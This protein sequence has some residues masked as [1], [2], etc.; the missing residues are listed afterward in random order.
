[1]LDGWDVW[2]ITTLRLDKFSVLL[3]GP[4]LFCVSIHPDL[5]RL[6]SE[7]VAGFMDDLT[8]GGPAERVAADIDH[9][10]DIQEATGLRNNASKRE[11]I[12]CG[13]IPLAAL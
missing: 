5:Q 12:S 6:Q 13:P 10:R 3:P 7:L 1:M 8:L 4:L 9:I 2:L 11:I